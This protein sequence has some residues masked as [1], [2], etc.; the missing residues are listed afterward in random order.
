MFLA[1]IYALAHG[2]GSSGSSLF[3][4]IKFRNSQML[5]KPP[6]E[7]S[8]ILRKTA[9]LD[10]LNSDVSDAYDKAQGDMMLNTGIA[11][12]PECLKTL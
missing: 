5:I 1:F 6:I 3:Q 10:A 4:A 7:A 2:K 8:S 9:F 12:P 11:V